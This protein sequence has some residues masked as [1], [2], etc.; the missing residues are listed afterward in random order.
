MDDDAPT[1]A[2]RLAELVYSRRAALGLSQKELAGRNGAQISEAT[3]RVIE[4]G[5]AKSLRPRTATALIAALDWPPYALDAIAQGDPAD[6]A[7]LELQLRTVGDVLAS[8]RESG[9]ESA[10]EVDEL[11]RHVREIEEAPPLAG[12]FPSAADSAEFRRAAARSTRRQAPP[13]DEVHQRLADLE[14]RVQAI[15]AVL[16]LDEL[17]TPG[18][19]R[20]RLPVES[21]EGIEHEPGAADDGVA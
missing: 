17:D 12:R 10:D 5:R 6:D 1:L 8:I 21:I 19:L 11:A 16:E 20:S 7:E 9:A 14:A 3:I 15:E 2:E 4:S 13:D 18:E